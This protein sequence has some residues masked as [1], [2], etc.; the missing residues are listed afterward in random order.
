MVSFGELADIIDLH[1]HSEGQILSSLI[2]IYV[3]GANF[4]TPISEGEISVPFNEL[5][6]FLFHLYYIILY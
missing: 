6:H 2:I 1:T 5:S 4:S 3:K